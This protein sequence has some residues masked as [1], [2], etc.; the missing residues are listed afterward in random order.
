MNQKELEKIAAVG[1]DYVNPKY[2][3]MS[4]K[5]AKVKCAEHL[6]E[7]MCKC[8]HGGEAMRRFLTIVAKQYFITQEHCA[9][10]RHLGY[11]FYRMLMAEGIEI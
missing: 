7:Q 10:I 1:L 4:R 11:A 6:K 5:N 9:K 8:K 3:Q 2:L